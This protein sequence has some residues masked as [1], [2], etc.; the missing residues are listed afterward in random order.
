MALDESPRSASRKHHKRVAYALW[1][2]A[3]AAEEWS[4]SCGVRHING[5]R[6]TALRAH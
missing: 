3:V 6:L 5:L 1:M 4:G 2:K